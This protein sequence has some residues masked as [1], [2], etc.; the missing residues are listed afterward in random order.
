[1]GRSRKSSADSRR[2]RRERQSQVI[3][4]VCSVPAFL[5]SCVSQKSGLGEDRFLRNAG[6][7]ECRNGGDDRMEHEE[8]TGTI[9][10]AAIAVHR[11]LGPG[12]RRRSRNAS[13]GSL[14]RGRD[15][16]RAR[17]GQGHHRRARRRGALLGERSSSGGERGGTRRAR[18]SRGTGQ[19]RRVY[20]VSGARGGGAAGER[21]RSGGARRV[22]KSSP[23]EWSSDGRGATR[24]RASSP[25]DMRH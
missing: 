10:G 18:A 4:N 20:A 13:S 6:M 5:P 22:E 1:M 15:R 7:D 17:A 8:L 2:R 11:E 16:G 14:R 23:A 3:A 9:I 24:S 21:R 19:A 12:F 25:R